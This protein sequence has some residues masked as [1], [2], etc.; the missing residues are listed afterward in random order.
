MSTGKLC[1]EDVQSV[2][3]ESHADG[4]F[5]CGT[6]INFLLLVADDVQQ[7]ASYTFSIRT[8]FHEWLEPR[9][10]L[11]NRV[12][13][14]KAVASKSVNKIL[15]VRSRQ[16]LGVA[17]RQQTHR[18]GGISGHLHAFAGRNCSIWVEESKTSRRLKQWR[19]NR[20]KQLAMSPI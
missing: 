4:L 5:R 13:C 7:T 3:F 10:G 6:F 17:T 2:N 8:W 15:G 20:F 19:V 18:C 9:R 16:H 14:R 1:Q 12:D 11:I